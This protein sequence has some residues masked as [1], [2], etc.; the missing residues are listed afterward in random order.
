MHKLFIL[1]LFIL[2]SSCKLNPV[3]KTHGVL[4]LEKK[5]KNLIIKKTNQNDI[6]KILGPP[7]TKGTFDNTVWIYIERVRSRGSIFKLGKNI[8]TKN[9]ALVLEFDKYGVWSN[10]EFYDITKNNK[11]K[12]SE[13][14]TVTINKERDFIYNFLSSVRQK[15]NNPLYKKAASRP[16]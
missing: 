13:N 5:Q 2:F 7:S 9:N 1:V 6:I 16:N 11:I 15:I 3:N 10:K 4:Y 12:F 14:K 8:T